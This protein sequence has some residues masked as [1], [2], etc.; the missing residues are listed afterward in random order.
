MNERPN[1]KKDRLM[2]FKKAIGSR[3]TTV[4]AVRI[5]VGLVVLFLIA[6]TIFQWNRFSLWSTAVEARRADVERELQRR[7]NLI[8][9]IVSAVG[10][11][12]AHEQG[13]FKHVSEVRTEL[14]KVKSSGASPAQI[15]S[16][17]EKALSGLVALA[18]SYPDLKATNSIQ[19][20][21]KEA[22][23]TENR[24]ADAKKEYNKACEAYMQCKTVFPG[25]FFG[26]IFGF[27]PISYIG[28]EEAVRVP[29]VD[30]DMTGQ[31]ERTEGNSEVNNIDAGAI[32]K[33]EIK[34]EKGSEV[35]LENLEKTEGVKK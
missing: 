26:F 1:R 32:T 31:R 27:K 12:A 2:T 30:L 24:I 18:E 34:K 35:E 5:L 13:V 25:N 20:L 22:A 3:R 17:L 9:N 33:K 21:I 10:K 6:E 8:P 7:E 23:N 19:D 28:L 14:K 11:Y 29:V 4:W 16:V 15:S